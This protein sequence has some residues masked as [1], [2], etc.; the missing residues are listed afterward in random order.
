MHVDSGWVAVHN[1]VTHACSSCG[2]KFRSDSACVG[3]ESDAA[4]MKYIL[5][6]VVL[7]CED[8]AFMWVYL[9]LAQSQFANDESMHYARL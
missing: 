5:L 6:N 8:I 7:G 3:I 9:M 1:H 2:S 4:S